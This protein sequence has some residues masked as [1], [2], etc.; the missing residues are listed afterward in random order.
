MQTKY[1]CLSDL[2]TVVVIKGVAHVPAH[3]YIP[4]VRA[5]HRIP[6]KRCFGH[7]F[8]RIVSYNKKHN[9]QHNSTVV[10]MIVE[11]QVSNVASGTTTLHWARGHVVVFE[12]GQRSKSM[13]TNTVCC[14]ASANVRAHNE[15]ACD[16]TDDMSTCI[17]T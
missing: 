1:T 9:A 12:L 2:D 8:A 4:H 7:I 11:K 10:G 3:Q 16:T 6:A 14:T 5:G 17:F 15:N 13:G